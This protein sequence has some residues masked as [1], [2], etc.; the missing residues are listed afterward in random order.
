M[1]FC[2]KS[3]ILLV[4]RFRRM[5]KMLKQRSASR[6]LGLFMCMILLLL[7][8]SY[9]EQTALVGKIDFRNAESFTVFASEGLSGYGESTV[10]G[11]VGVGEGRDVFGFPPSTI[12]GVKHIHDDLVDQ[13]SYDLDRVKEQ[14]LEL[15]PTGFTTGNISGQTFSP[16]VYKSDSPLFIQGT[17]VL[18]GKDINDAVCVMQVYGDLKVMQ[19]SNVNVTGGLNASNVYWVVKGKVTFERDT[20]FVGTILAT[21]DIT[22]DYNTTIDGRLMTVA[23]KVAMTDSHLSFEKYSGDSKVII[24][25]I[26]EVP[27]ASLYV[28]S[29]LINDNGGV[30]QMNDLKLH[31]LKD[32][33]D[34]TNSPAGGVDAPGKMYFLPLGTYKVNSEAAPGYKITYTGDLDV[35]GNVALD[36][37][38]PKTVVVTIDDIYNG[39]SVSEPVTVPKENPEKKP[40]PKMGIKVLAYGNPNNLTKPDTV[41]FVYTVTNTGA[42]PLSKV[43]VADPQVKN[44]K[45]ISGDTNHNQ[46]LDVNESWIY[47]AKAYVKKST[48]FRVTVKGSSGAKS[49]YSTSVTKI[50]L[51]T[52]KH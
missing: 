10:K 30:L 40:E 29:K 11:D 49:V 15:V 45:Y 3:G 13:A 50:T 42:V 41:A 28:V 25:P 18:D 22:T 32:N 26:V 16:G 21:G 23:G 35:N 46:K 24:N 43:L 39:K 38:N 6:F 4:K 12:D 37:N 14:I 52:V 51:K 47:S 17:T 27:E 48:T 8:P 2:S 44:I 5:V 1:Y 19:G 7:T 34:V 9:A 31:V 33:A 36:Y 20:H